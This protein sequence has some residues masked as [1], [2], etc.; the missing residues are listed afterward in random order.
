MRLLLAAFCS[1]S[2]L[3]CLA[4]EAAGISAGAEQK[5]CTPAMAALMERA[6]AMRAATYPESS[7]NGSS[8]SSW[9]S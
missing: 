3:H 5:A 9:S 8:A 1:L 6:R 2:Q 7:V 4:G